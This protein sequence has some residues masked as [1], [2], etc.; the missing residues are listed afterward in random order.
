MDESPMGLRRRCTHCGRRRKVVTWWEDT[1]ARIC[2]SCG[3][4][5]DV[6]FQYSLRG[7]LAG[8]EAFKELCHA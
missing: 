1:G 4:E 3:R 5:E 2:R 8:L 6:A 7:G